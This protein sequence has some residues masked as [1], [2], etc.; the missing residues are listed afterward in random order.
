[1]LP[2]IR[3]LTPSDFSAIQCHFRV[4]PE[5]PE[6]ISVMEP[7]QKHVVTFD[8][9]D[10]IFITNSVDDLDDEDEISISEN[11]NRTANLSKTSS[12]VRCEGGDMNSVSSISTSILDDAEEVKALKAKLAE[13]DTRCKLLE[14]EVEKSN[15]CLINERNQNSKLEKKLQFVKDNQDVFIRLKEAYINMK[16][17][18]A[19]GRKM[20]EI[21]EKGSQTWEGI[22]C[23]GCI[24]AEELRRELENVRETYKDSCIIAPFE[25]EQL[26]N[27]V[28][29]L[30][31]LIERREKSWA[32]KVDRENKLQPHLEHLENENSA[33]RNLIKSRSNDEG[34]YAE[35]DNFVKND[36]CTIQMKKIIIKYEKRIREIEK[37]NSGILKLNPS[38]NEKEKKIIGQ[39]MS[40][41][42][43]KLYCKSRSQSSVGKSRPGSR[44]SCLKSKNEETTNQKLKDTERTP[45]TTLLMMDYLF[46]NEYVN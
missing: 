24:E 14:Y 8:D 27:T 31:D 39:I 25:L 41:Y 38:F 29:Y 42:N 20:I 33:L 3:N 2:V 30:K 37:N 6:I 23:R 9:N 19:A 15:C 10:Q 12:A 18:E 1:S 5:S 16:Y 17:N 43:A 13:A 45:D 40:K 21:R 7:Q 32:E 22:L 34:Y 44:G 46:E 26:V 35:T 11:E 28:K 4:N 36:D